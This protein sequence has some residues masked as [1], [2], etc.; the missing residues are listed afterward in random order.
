VVEVSKTRGSNL[1]FATS[2]HTFDIL[3]VAL[4][5]LCTTPNNAKKRLKTPENASTR[6]AHNFHQ[7][8]HNA[9]Q[10]PA[11]CIRSG[12]NPDSFRQARVE[13]IEFYRGADQPSQ[14]ETTGP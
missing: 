7:N 13:A 9:E 14:A 2:H 4:Y 8:S 6:N 11:D 5:N 1:F 10:R 3:I 12:N